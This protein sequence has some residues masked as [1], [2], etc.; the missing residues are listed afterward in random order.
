MIVHALRDD[1]ST[2]VTRLRPDA[3]R[4][5]HDVTRPL[6]QYNAIAHLM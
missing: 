1:S 5:L 6:T 2:G 4:V 3:T